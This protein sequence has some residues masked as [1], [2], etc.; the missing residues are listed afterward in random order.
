MIHQPR[1]EIQP[2]PPDSEPLSGWHQCLPTKGMPVASAVARVMARMSSGSTLF[3]LV[4]PV[5]RAIIEASASC[6]LRIFAVASRR[7]CSVKSGAKRSPLPS[8]I[9]PPTARPTGMA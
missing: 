7:S 1:F 5:Q 3:K 6:A 4:L 9:S 8:T 2:Q